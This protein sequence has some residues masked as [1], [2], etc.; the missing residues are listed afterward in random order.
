MKPIA[1]CDYVYDERL[2]NKRKRGVGAYI[3]KSFIGS[4]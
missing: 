1:S 4:Y 3:K 2:I